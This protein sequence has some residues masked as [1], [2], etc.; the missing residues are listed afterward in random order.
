MGI[1]ASGS[2]GPYRV[3][4]G[5]SMRPSIKISKSFISW[6]L[7]VSTPVSRTKSRPAPRPAMPTLFCVPLSR[8]SGKEIRLLFLIGGAA[9]PAAFQRPDGKPFSDVES[10]G[11][12]RPVQSFV[13]RER[14]EID[15]HR[16]HVDGERSSGLC[17]VQKQTALVRQPL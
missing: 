6:R 7:I 17:R 3:I 11:S 15:A 1:C 2:S 8:A 12:L 9:G 13:P 5:T 10:A 14:E 4:P 16:L